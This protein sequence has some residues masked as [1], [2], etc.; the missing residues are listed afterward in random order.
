M[1]VLNKQKENDMLETAWNMSWA[2]AH[3]KHQDN[4]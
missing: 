2:Q 1:Q 3:Y 4:I